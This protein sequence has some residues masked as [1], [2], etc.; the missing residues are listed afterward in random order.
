M[1]Y[2]PSYYKTHFCE[3]F[4]TILNDRYADVAP[5][6]RR[7]RFTEDYDNLYPSE[8]GASVSSSLKQ[9]LAASGQKVPIVENL[10][11]VCNVLDCDVD[12]FLTEQESFRKEIADTSQVTGLNYKTV[13]HIC[14]YSKTHK[15][16]LDVM[17]NP[18]SF[19]DEDDVY[20]IPIESGTDYLF[21]LLSVIHISTSFGPF[22]S[23]HIEDDVLGNTANTVTSEETK[24]LINA[25][26]S[27]RY[28]EILSVLRKILFNGKFYFAL[29][30]AI[31][32]E[33]EKLFALGMDQLD[34]D[35][36][37]KRT[38]VDL[39]DRASDILKHNAH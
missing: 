9:W 3:K 15:R 28:T 22:T 6:R 23:V 26:A 34:I 1:P 10:M 39:M 38:R 12:Y 32:Q 25:Y 31:R 2:D 20:E 21:Q 19:A 35:S 24:S 33:K 29:D 30:D 14:A 7:G 4:Y 27:L 37:I 16:M 18:I 11:K 13:E 17:T 5:H 8:K 36:S